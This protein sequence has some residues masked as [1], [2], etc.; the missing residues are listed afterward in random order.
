M[1]YGAGRPEA[2]QGAF[3]GPSGGP[4]GPK[5]G[6]DCPGANCSMLRFAPLTA[7]SHR[8]HPKTAR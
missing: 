4:G 3:G 2:A 5:G 6:T 8:R 1:K 7:D